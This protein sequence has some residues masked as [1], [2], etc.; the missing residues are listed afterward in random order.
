MASMDTLLLWYRDLLAAK[1]Q[2]EV[3]A[4]VNSDRRNEIVR[5]ASLYPNAESLQVILKSI[6]STRR[7][8]LGNAN[9]QIQT[10]ALLA[11]MALAAKR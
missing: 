5:Q 4:L 6:L 9:A 3:A 11:K 2:G 8:I 10:E 7:S 1:L